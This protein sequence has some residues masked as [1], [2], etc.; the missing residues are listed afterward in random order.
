VFID[1]SLKENDDCIYL[2]NQAKR[3]MRE[4]DTE[5]NEGHDLIEFFFSCV[6]CN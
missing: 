4:K 3:K 1:W 6:S 2:F 5:R